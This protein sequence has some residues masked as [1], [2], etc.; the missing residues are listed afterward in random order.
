MHSQ[1]TKNYQLD[2]NLISSILQYPTKLDHNNFI[3]RKTYKKPPLLSNIILFTTFLD[4]ISYK[5][6]T[7]KNVRKL[8]K[9][10]C[11]ACGE[12]FIRKSWPVKQ[13]C[14]VIAHCVQQQDTNTPTHRQ[15]RS[16]KHVI[17]KAKRKK[18]K[19][20]PI[21]HQDHQ[22]SCI[23]VGSSMHDHHYHHHHH[24]LLHHQVHQLVLTSDVAKRSRSKVA[25]IVLCTLLSGLSDQYTYIQYINGCFYRHIFE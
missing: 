21:N 11:S 13:V 10:S 22:E 15:S 4:C 9:K 5:N 24:S 20:Q 7:P 8:Q 25:F 2:L 12:K 14:Q 6:K 18:K 16:E 19:D 3:Y 17:L 23:I 1:W